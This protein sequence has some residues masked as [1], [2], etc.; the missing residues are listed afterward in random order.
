MEFF[1]Y[2]MPNKPSMDSYQPNPEDIFEP[3]LDQ[4]IEW[5]K[6][7]HD[8][9]HEEDRTNEYFNFDYKQQLV[10]ENKLVDIVPLDFNIFCHKTR[11]MY[12]KLKTKQKSDIFD[13]DK[14]ILFRRLI[15]FVGPYETY[16]DYYSRIAR[17]YGPFQ[18][19]FELALASTL[20]PYLIDKDVN[21]RIKIIVCTAD[22]KSVEFEFTPNTLDASVIRLTL[23]K[24]NLISHLLYHRI[25]KIEITRALDCQQSF[26]DVDLNA[27][28]DKDD[29]P[30]YNIKQ[31]MLHYRR[32]LQPIT[33]PTGISTGW[34]FSYLRLKLVSLIRT[35]LTMRNTL[36]LASLSIL[37]IAA[38]SVIIHNRTRCVGETCID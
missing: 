33:N 36:K 12:K 22:E 31:C 16:D 35:K 6:L 26:E 1:L 28:E 38:T 25:F 9:F 17:G 27:N 18:K 30:F 2:R 7:Y 37:L 10:Q 32:S 24:Q 23:I 20:K 8:H 14:T 19:D 29:D 34:N 15:Q 5:Y 3:T 4:E 11:E 13:G 21:Y